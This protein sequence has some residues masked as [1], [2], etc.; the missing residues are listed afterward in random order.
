M[1][2]EL[3]LKEAASVGL[4]P[5][6]I[7]G[8]GAEV[9]E[10]GRTRECGGLTQPLALVETPKRVVKLAGKPPVPVLLEVR[11]CRARHQHRSAFHKCYCSYYQGLSDTACCPCQADQSAALHDNNGCQSS[12]MDQGLLTGRHYAVV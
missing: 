11:I 3:L 2:P 1:H 6:C 5:L 7:W 12:F 10:E 8:S 4:Q 9:Q